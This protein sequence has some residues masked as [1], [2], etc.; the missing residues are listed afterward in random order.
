MK[1]NQPSTEK[2]EQKQSDSNDAREPIRI[3]IIT[4]GDVRVGKSCLIKKISAP[5]RFVSNYIPTIGV[6]Y[7]VKTI[8]KKMNCG[9]RTQEMKIDF[10]DISGKMCPKGDVQG[11]G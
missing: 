5:N 4:V 2:T 1:Q 6:D 10:F 7:G 8:S 9:G 11:R 3:R